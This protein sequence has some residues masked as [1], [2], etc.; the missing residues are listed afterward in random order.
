M[1]LGLF[2]THC[3]L[4]VERFDA[5][6]DAVWQR[7]LDAGV[8]RMLNPAFNMQSSRRAAL[9]AQRID[10]VCA[11]VGIHPNDAPALDARALDELRELARAPGVVAIG[12]I[13]LDN[14]WK[15]VPPDVQERA[16][17]TQLGL[18]RELNL[19]VIIHCREAEPRM[20]EILEA[21]WRGR[22]LVL[23]SFAGDTA[24]LERA[25]DCGFYIGVSGPVTYPSAR[26]SRD[27]VRAAPLDRLLIETDAPYLTPQRYRGKRNEPAYVR[28]VA[29]KIADVRDMLIDDVARATAENARAL[30]QL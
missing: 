8:T 1:T 22:P 7:A 13:G 10:G 12:E 29:E 15:T 24:Q 26:G 16:F 3:H 2:D 19:P 25:L 17:L 9:L 14:H 11:A 21:E 5:D 23:H 27:V 20:L 4:D 18:A 6:R 28:L 30:F